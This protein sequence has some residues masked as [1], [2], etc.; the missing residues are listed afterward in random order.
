MDSV[1]TSWNRIDGTSSIQ[2]M[3]NEAIQQ[4]SIE[5]PAASVPK[6]INILDEIRN[7]PNGNWKNQK[8]KET[9]RLIQ[10]LC[11]PLVRSLFCANHHCTGGHTQ[12]EDPGN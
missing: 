8:R 5:N 6:L 9:E 10:L 12:L 4:Y 3:V 1:T 7:L 2:S 11:R